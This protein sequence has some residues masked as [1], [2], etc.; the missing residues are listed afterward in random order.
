MRKEQILAVAISLFG[1]RKIRCFVLDRKIN[2]HAFQPAG[3]GIAQFNRGADLLIF[4]VMA[5]P[6]ALRRLRVALPIILCASEGL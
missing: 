3:G 4:A 1:S 2:L 6:K 5:S